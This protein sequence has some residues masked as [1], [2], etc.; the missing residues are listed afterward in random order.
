ME[1]KKDHNTVAAQPTIGIEIQKLRD[2]ITV[3]IPTLNEE[4]AIG[5]LIDEIRAAGYD[6]IL[7]VDG[8]SKDETARIAAEH[9]AKV[10]GQHGKGK[11]GAILVARDVV[12]TQY[13]LLMDGDYTYDPSDIDRFALHE[14]GYDHIVGFRP[15]RCAN[16]SKVHRFGNWVLTKTFNVLMGSN[17]PDVACGMY[18]MRTQKMQELTLEV[19]G[20]AID[21][22]IIAQM[23][24]DGKIAFVPINYR[25]RFGKAK[26]PTWRQGFS[27][28]FTI[29]NLAR[30]FNPILLFSFLAG[31]ALIPAVLVLGYG[32]YEYLLLGQYHGGYFLT[33]VVLFVLGIQGLTVAAVGSML[34]RI[35]RK[36]SNRL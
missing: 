34:R 7:V 17:V 10:F 6:K 1:V 24:I 11:A 30:R 8:Y 35:E 36:T 22:E 4:E 20:F 9:G 28:L 32:S 27:A 19:H 16:I 26:A 5:R 15:K 3:V 33:G 13:F 14:N 12:D 18:L 23:L 31:L 25:G 21:Q 29:I 2:H